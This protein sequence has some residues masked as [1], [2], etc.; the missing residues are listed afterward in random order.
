VLR[1]VVLG[2]QQLEEPTPDT[3]ELVTRAV[4]VAKAVQGDD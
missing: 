4:T 2:L 3:A 1:L